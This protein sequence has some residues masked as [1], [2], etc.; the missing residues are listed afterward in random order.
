MRTVLLR[1]HYGRASV[2]QRRSQAEPRKERFF[3]VPW[4]QSRRTRARNRTSQE[5]SLSNKK[6]YQSYPATLVVLVRRDS[7]I[8]RNSYM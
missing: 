8:H 7:Y 3:L 2:A 6:K 5:A 4:R 1:W